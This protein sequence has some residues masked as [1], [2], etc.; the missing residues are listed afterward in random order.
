MYVVLTYV[1]KNLSDIADTLK[2]KLRH[3]KAIPYS[4]LF[5][6]QIF[7]TSASKSISVVLFRKFSILPCPIV[8]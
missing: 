8:T 1:C 7:S 2:I 4:G 6:N 5:S 3:H